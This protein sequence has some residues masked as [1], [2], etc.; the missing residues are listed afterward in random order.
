MLAKPPTAL[1]YTLRERGN[2]QAIGAFPSAVPRDDHPS[3]FALTGP[4]RLPF[5][6]TDRALAT[7]FS[8]APLGVIAFA[9]IFHQE[10]WPHCRGFLFE[11]RNCGQRALGDCWVGVD[12]CRVGR[13]DSWT[14]EE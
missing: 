12:P 3:A 10:G 8:S 9:R 1:V 4:D 7:C 2:V 11:Y 13:P 5:G 6:F 14:L